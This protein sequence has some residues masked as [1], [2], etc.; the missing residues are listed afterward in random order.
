MITEN[1][2]LHKIWDR[3]NWAG[4]LA[5]YGRFDQDTLTL[6]VEESSHQPPL[7]F[8]MLPLTLGLDLFTEHYNMSADSVEK[9]HNWYMKKFNLEYDAT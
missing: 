6:Y 8:G 7:V 9:L 2:R 5:S 4:T 1:D 3:P